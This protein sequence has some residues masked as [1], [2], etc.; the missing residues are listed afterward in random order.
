VAV[1]LN[2]QRRRKNLPSNTYILFC[3]HKMLPIFK[4]SGGLISI[5]VKLRH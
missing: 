4:A 5:Y 2:Q 1:E 3:M